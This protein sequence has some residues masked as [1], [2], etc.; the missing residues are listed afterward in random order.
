MNDVSNDLQLVGDALE[1]AW[2]RDHVERARRTRVPGRRR[3]ALVAALGAVTLGG[4]AAIAGDLLKSPAQEEAGLVGG[5]QLFEGSRPTCVRRSASSFHCA[6][7]MPPTGMT[8]YN[9]DG[10]RA[11]DRFLGVTAETVDASRRVDG[12][13]VAVSADG[14]S[15]DCYLGEAAVSRGLISR[16]LLGVYVAGP[17]TG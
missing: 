1:R 10:T 12:A 13:C 9:E 3:L 14:R 7:Q 8:F 11:L 6:L 2:R 15:W 17:V 5:Y 16:S 4:G